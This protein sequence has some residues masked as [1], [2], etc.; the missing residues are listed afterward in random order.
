MNKQIAIL[1][2]TSS[3]IFSCQQADM[4]SLDKVTSDFQVTQSVTPSLSPKYP[5]TE[6]DMKQ[7]SFTATV[8]YMNLEGGFFGLFASDGKHWLPMNLNKTFQQ[9]GAV[10]KVRGHAVEGLMTIQQWGEPFSI[11]H[12]ELIKAGRNG[13]AKNLH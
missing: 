4:K 3:L 2:L 8:K 1:A 5:S 12:I 6:A 11:T 9:D 10:I 7:L 13:T